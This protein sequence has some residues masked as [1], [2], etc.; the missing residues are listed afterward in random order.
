M[1]NVYDTIRG[2]FEERGDETEDGTIVLTAQ[3]W[4]H[5]VVTE[6]GSDDRTIKAWALRF[7]AH[8]CVSTRPPVDV[9]DV[10]RYG[11][12]AVRSIRLFIYT[13]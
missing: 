7:L 11:M 9:F 2:V 13:K 8:P 12:R 3:R 5:W 4:L 10:S 6:R 1:K